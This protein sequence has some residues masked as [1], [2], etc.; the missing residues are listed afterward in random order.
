MRG[1][2]V[3]LPWPEGGGVITNLGGEIFYLVVSREVLL[4]LYIVRL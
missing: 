1:G 4:I 3:P 2:L